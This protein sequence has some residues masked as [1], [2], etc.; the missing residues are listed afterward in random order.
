MRQGRPTA[1]IAAGEVQDEPSRTLRRVLCF[2]AVVVAT[3]AGCHGSATTPTGLSQRPVFPLTVTR[4][5]SVAELRDRLVVTADGLVSISR[6]GQLLLG[7]INDL[8]G[9]TAYRLC[10]PV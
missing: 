10:P 4:S 1:V 8:N 6:T 5:G 7:V 3:T 2:V 9:P